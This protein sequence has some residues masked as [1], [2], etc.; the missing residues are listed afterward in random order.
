MVCEFIY[1]VCVCCVCAG[2]PIWRC[3]SLCL[4]LQSWETPTAWPLLMVGSL[5][6]LVSVSFTHQ[7]S[8][9]PLCNQALSTHTAQ[10]HTHTRPPLSALN[11]PSLSIPHRHTLVFLISMVHP[12]IS[13]H[14]LSR[15]HYCKQVGLCVCACV[16]VSACVC[17]FAS[18]A[19]IASHFNSIVL[20]WNVAETLSE[21]QLN[22]ALCGDVEYVFITF[23]KQR[24][25]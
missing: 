3:V 24:L 23:V 14:L 10:H 2:R 25:M 21:T 19:L 12:R 20:K 5:F 17:V 11:T 13:P 6:L 7:R 1:S 4:W 18:T 9:G 22:S 15:K 8:A 16:W